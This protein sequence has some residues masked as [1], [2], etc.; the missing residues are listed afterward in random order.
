MQLKK[1][2]LMWVVLAILAMSTASMAWASHVNVA[3]ENGNLVSHDGAPCHQAQNGITW[4]CG[5]AGNK[6]ISTQTSSQTP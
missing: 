4:I 5:K 2:L 3:F 1:V 6:V